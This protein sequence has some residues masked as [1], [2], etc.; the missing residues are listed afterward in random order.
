MQ[1]LEN[2]SLKE[3]N[4]FGI[5]V[6][7]KHFV[8]VSSLDQLK[9]VFSSE[10]FPKKFILGGGS[11]MLLTKDID[12]LVVHLNLKGKQILSKTETEAFVESQAGENWHDFV[13]WTL[14]NN[15]GGLENLS[16]IP[17]NVGTSPIQNIGAY[18]VE[19]KDAFYS[20]KA[21]NLETL[22]VETF[23]N[24][25]CEFDYRNSIFKQHAK[26]KYII[27]SVIFKLTTKNHL[28]HTNYGAITSELE[29]MSIEQP[30]IQDIS[31]AVIAIRESKLPNPKKIGNS[32]SFFKNPIISKDAFL[33]LQNNFPNAPH[34]VVSDT[35]IKVPA[36]WLIEHAG[37]KGKTFN[38]Y[39]VHKKQALV[40]VSYG[41]AKGEDILKLAQLIQ[42]TIYR[43]FEIKIETEVN[44][45]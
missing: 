24:L 40:L 27:I 10:A 33:K 16:L 25:Q 39:G 34:Y 31:K 8:S 37:F 2:I 9:T 43:L 4:T 13:L 18:G 14:D 5:D 44:I 26:G 42:K 17:G 11:N 19:L 30:T 15:F 22:E 41:G 6:K 21:L 7:A 12:A 3:Y 28:L 32:G 20:C 35:E 23:S 45:I 1:I 29:S 38:N 36:G